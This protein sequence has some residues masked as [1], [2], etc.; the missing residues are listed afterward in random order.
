MFEEDVDGVDDGA[1]QIVE[2]TAG[3]TPR[4]TP[5]TPVQKRPSARTTRPAAPRPPNS[6]VRAVERWNAAVAKRKAPGERIQQGQVEDLRIRLE[7]RK[8]E[9]ALQQQVENGTLR[10]ATEQEKTLAKLFLL[11]LNRTRQLEQDK[12]SLQDGLTRLLH[13]HEELKRKSRAACTKKPPAA[14]RHEDNQDPDG[15]AVGQQTPV[16]TA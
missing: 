4:P 12:V 6:N 7:A 8:Q 5:T 16:A 10:P 11:Q 14:R 2:P 13:D 15:G 3:D 1:K 9:Q